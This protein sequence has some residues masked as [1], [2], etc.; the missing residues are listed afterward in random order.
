MTPDDCYCFHIGS[1]VATDSW[2]LPDED[3]SPERRLQVLEAEQ[4]RLAA[5]GDEL[6]EGAALP[7]VEVLLQ[8][9]PQPVDHSVRIVEAAVIMRVLAKI[10][11]SLG[12]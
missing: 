3:Q 9:V 2:P 4:G 5:A 7:V 11:R 1:N 6:Q 12:H 8:H 10:L